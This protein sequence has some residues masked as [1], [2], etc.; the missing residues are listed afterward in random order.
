MRQ[1][2]HHITNNVI[3]LESLAVIYLKDAE[4]MDICIM[5]DKTQHI[6]TQL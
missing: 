1:R 6:I 3:Y 2:A 5:H 4:H